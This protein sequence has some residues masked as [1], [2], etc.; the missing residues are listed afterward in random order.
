MS[1]KNFTETINPDNRFNFLKEEQYEEITIGADCT[2]TFEFDF[3]YSDVVFSSKIFYRQGLADIV[4]ETD[5]SANNYLQDEKENKSYLTVRLPL[6]ITS[7]FRK[8]N[9]DTFAQVRFELK[10][11]NVIFSDKYKIIIKEP[12]KVLIP[13]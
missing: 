10:S 6:D 8:T 4:Y 2:N 7:L 9:L 12:L 1:I 13:N 3:I 11:G 5:L